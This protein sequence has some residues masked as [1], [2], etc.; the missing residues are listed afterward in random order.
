MGK[1]SNEA[2][3]VPVV[4]LFREPA[5]PDGALPDGGAPGPAGVSCRRDERGFHF[6]QI[7]FV[8]VG[9]RGFET[10]AFVELQTEQTPLLRLEEYETEARFPFELCP[11]TPGGPI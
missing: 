2:C 1:I 9:K 5:E 3:I 8:G 11:S 7:K 10:A 4:R 6:V